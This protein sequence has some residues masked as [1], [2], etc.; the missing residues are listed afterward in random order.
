MEEALCDLEGLQGLYR[1]IGSYSLFE[2]GAAEELT[3]QGLGYWLGETWGLG[4]I[5]VIDEAKASAVF[6]KKLV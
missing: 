3:D 1:R 4:S 2:L 6:I 5:V